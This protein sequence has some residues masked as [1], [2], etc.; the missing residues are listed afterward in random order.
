MNGISSR[1]AS[2]GGTPNNYKYNGK[3][4]QAA[5]FS[6]G[7]GLNWYD[8]GARMYDNQ[9]GRWMVID[10]LAE[11]SRRWTPY[12]YSYNN[13]L[14][15]IDPDGMKAIAI[16]EEQ[17]GFQELTGFKRYGQDWDDGI[18]DDNLE[19][20]ADAIRIQVKM[21]Q[22]RAISRKLGSIMTGGGG[23]GGSSTSC[24]QFDFNKSLKTGDKILVGT[25]PIYLGL[26]FVREHNRDNTLN[27]FGNLIHGVS[28]D[29]DWRNFDETVVLSTVWIQTITRTVP[30][31]PNLIE[32]YTD[33]ETS[34]KQGYWPS[35]YS[36]NDKKE[37]FF[38]VR[39]SFDDRFY[40]Q[41]G[42]NE[43][44][45]VQTFKGELTL[46]GQNKDGIYAPLISFNYYFSVMPTTNKVISSHLIVT[47]MS[48]NGYTNMSLNQSN[49]IHGLN[50]KKYR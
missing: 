50:N 19:A 36:E 24:S 48:P 11:T 7:F 12:N 23:N 43:R 8:Y 42:F 40:D 18:A 47:S 34:A 46:V 29:L 6:D 2:F 17:G 32:T 3:E 41:P 35:F 31:S 1:A 27:N 5:E 10:P 14:R 21:I 9:V 45:Y 26:I 33:P 28:V 25:G 37:S 15:F 39:E 38:A 13:P 30:N 16:N 20:L 49:N 22:K 44:S 4:Q